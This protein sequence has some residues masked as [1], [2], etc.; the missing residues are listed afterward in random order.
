MFTCDGRVTANV[1]HSATSSAVR[2]VRP[3]YTLAAR[4]ASPS[5]RTSENSV[6]HVPGIDLGDT[7]RT[8]EQLHAQHL[9]ERVHGELRGV[10]TRASD[11]TLEPGDGTHQHDMAV[12]RRFELRE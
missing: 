3:S 6:S 9:M 5:K 2:G 8:A 4:S 7:D 11:V 1:T 10:V 12:S